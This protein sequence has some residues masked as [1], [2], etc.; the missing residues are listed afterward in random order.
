MRHVHR[1]QGFDRDGCKEAMLAYFSCLREAASSAVAPASWADP[2]TYDS[3]RGH[4]T[5]MS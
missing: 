1:A 2:V 5:I 4:M 3:A